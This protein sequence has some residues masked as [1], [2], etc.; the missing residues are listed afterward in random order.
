[1]HRRLHG[2][3]RSRLYIDRRLLDGKFA[4]DAG[5]ASEVFARR[6]FEPLALRQ[7]PMLSSQTAGFVYRTHNWRDEHLVSKQIFVLAGVGFIG[8]GP[9]VIERPKER[10]A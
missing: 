4:V 3:D 10:D 1:M 9:V 6:P 2:N 5:R 8:F 7:P